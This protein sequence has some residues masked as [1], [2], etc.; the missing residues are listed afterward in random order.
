LDDKNILTTHIFMNF[1][2]NFQ[3]REAS[4]GSIGQRNTASGGHSF[5]QGAVA[6]AG[7]NLH[8]GGTPRGG[9]DLRRTDT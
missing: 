8:A 7:N 5:G 9:N 2:E 6:V 3:I 1:N 4:D